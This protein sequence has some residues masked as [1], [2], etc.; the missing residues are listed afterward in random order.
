MV[1]SC[2]AEDYSIMVKLM[3]FMWTLGMQ[4]AKHTPPNIHKP[5]MHTT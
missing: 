4:H 3:Q 1:E 2:T 5:I